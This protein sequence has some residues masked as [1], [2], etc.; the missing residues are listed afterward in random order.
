MINS[1]CFYFFSSKE[2][3]IHNNFNE[4]K[5]YEKVHITLGLIDNLCHE[6]IYHKHDDMNYDNMTELIIHCI[7]NLFKNDLN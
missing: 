4:E 2:I 6:I 1:L 7:K 5:L 3:L